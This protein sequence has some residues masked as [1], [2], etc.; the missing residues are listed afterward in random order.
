MMIYDHVYIRSTDQFKQVG[1]REKRDDHVPRL[2]VHSRNF[3][4][5]RKSF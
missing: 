4:I 5:D 3:L 1:V 2:V